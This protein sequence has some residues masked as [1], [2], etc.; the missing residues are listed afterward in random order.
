MYIQIRAYGAVVETFLENVV[1]FLRK[2]ENISRKK[3]EW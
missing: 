2:H 3:S 1:Q